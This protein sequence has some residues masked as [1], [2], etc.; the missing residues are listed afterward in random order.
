MAAELI[1][2]FIKNLGKTVVE[3]LQEG[4]SIDELQS[5]MSDLMEEVKV[6]YVQTSGAAK[7]TPEV[8]VLGTGL[9]K[10]E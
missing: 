7:Q 6:N 5:L 9:I 4:D 3:E 8:T 10:R 2:Q 1:S